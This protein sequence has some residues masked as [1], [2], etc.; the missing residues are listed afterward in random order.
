MKRTVT[1]EA[2]IV[3]A[4]AFINRMVQDGGNAHNLKTASIGEP[5]ADI[6]AKQKHTATFEPSHGDRDG[7]RLWVDGKAEGIKFEIREGS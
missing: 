6:G 1:F 2:T 7:F 3:D 4:T 5:K